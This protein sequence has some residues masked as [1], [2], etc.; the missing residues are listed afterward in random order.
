MHELTAEPSSEIGPVV[1][2]LQTDTFCAGCGYNLNTQAVLRDARLDLLVCRCPECGR[3]TAAGQGT[4][5]A[6]VWLNRFGIL[7]LMIWLLFLFVIF[8]LGSLALG[9]LSYG[10]LMSLTT[11]RSQQIPFPNRPNAF[12]YK[13]HYELRAAFTMNQEAIRE[14]WVEEG[15]VIACGAALAFLLGALYSVFLWHLR[16]W[17]RYLCLVMP[18]LG[19]GGAICSWV[20][21]PMTLQIR[22]WGV[23]RL[24]LF[25]LLEWAAMLGGILLGRAVARGVLGLVLP[26]KV[27]QHLS[28]LWLRDGKRLKI[29]P[30]SA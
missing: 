25:L 20:L 29:E 8:G 21:D 7:L 13:S 30:V 22:N 17:R 16:G 2:H 5:A 15:I 14:M 27:R 12:Y 26:P 3:F 10:S 18:A 24:V 23:P 9:G 11:V 19:V 1:S 6:R 4:S 28:F